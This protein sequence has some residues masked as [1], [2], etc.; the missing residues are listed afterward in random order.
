MRISLQLDRPIGAHAHR[1]S[2]RFLNGVGADGDD[3]S[4]SRTLLLIQLKGN[5]HCVAREV[6]D[7]ELESGLVDAGTGG[8]NPEARLRIR[9]ALDT[10]GN[11]QRCTLAWVEFLS[12]IC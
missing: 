6:V 1:F 12:Q 5:L 10:D 7:V 11:S 3:H 8:G 4:L 2:E 9:R